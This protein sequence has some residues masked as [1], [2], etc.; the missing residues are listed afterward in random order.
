[1]KK[2]LGVVVV[3]LVLALVVALVSGTGLF[4]APAQESGGT[5]SIV[6][7]SSPPPALQSASGLTPQRIGIDITSPGDDFEPLFPLQ[8]HGLS[9]FPYYKQ[10]GGYAA[11]TTS[12]QR[13]CYN[14]LGEMVYWLSNTTNANG[15]YVMPHFTVEGSSLAEQDIRKVLAAFQEDHPEIFWIASVFGYTYSEQGTIVE[16][17]SPISPAACKEGMVAIQQAL[18]EACAVLQSGMPEFERELALHDWLLR[19]VT[20]DEQTAQDLARWQAFTAYGAL[21]EG[22]AV[23]EGYARAMQLLLSFANMPCRLVNG[24]GVDGLHMW[25]LVQV[26]GSWYH[27]DPTWNDGNAAAYQYF[28]LTDAGIQYDHTVAA[29][30]DEIPAEEICGRGEAQPCLFN[31]SLPDSRSW[32]NSFA[33][34]QAFSF[35]GFSSTSDQEAEQYLVDA[36]REGKTSVYFYIE[37][38]LDFQDTVDQLFV[39]SPL[40]FLYYIRQA[41]ER[42]PEAVQINEY[43]VSY[44]CMEYQRLVCVLFE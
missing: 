27:L 19:R 39:Q 28:N 25:N 23:C 13:D 16:L 33:R 4:A 3:A 5:S 31:L 42:L 12:A 9:P 24:S 29:D 10:A 15:Y 17:Y 44:L 8:T 30:F 21:A 26:E 38:G 6:D 41:N 1:M 37:E 22:S 36:A 2:H 43:Q 20:Y 11:L 40:K 34:K 18:R 32:Q 14:L 7:A 35:S